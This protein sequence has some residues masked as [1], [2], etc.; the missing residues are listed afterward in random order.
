MGKKK[1]RTLLFLLSLCWGGSSFAAPRKAPQLSFLVRTR[2]ER[3]SDAHPLSAAAVT[4][5]TEFGFSEEHILGVPGLAARIEVTDV[6]ALISRY[7][8]GSLSGPTHPQRPTVADPTLTRVTESYLSL[9]RGGTTLLLGRKKLS[10]DDE[11]FVGPVGWRQMPQSFGLLGVEGHPSAETDYFFAYLFQRKGIKDELNANYRTGSLL[12]HFD[13]KLAPLKV[14]AFAYLLENTHD[15]YG[16]ATRYQRKSSQALAEAAWQLPPTLQTGGG[17]PQ[18]RAF[19][20]RLSWDKEWGKLRAGLSLSFLGRARG[21]AVTGFSTP[22]A[23][24]HKFE[25]FA[26][27]LLSKSANGDPLG[28][29]DRELRLG[30]GRGNVI[31]HDFSSDALHKDYGRELDLS[32]QTTFRPVALLFKGAFYQAGRDFGKSTTKL[33]VVVEYHHIP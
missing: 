18:K 12:F 29:Q 7:N 21:G 4:T 26:D 20:Y 15:T 32:Y 11:R 23:T 25:G 8:A 6:S 31:L 28:V 33:W 3:V 2:F 16:L 27:V 1:L 13:R 30:F 22:L 19:F 24:L 10:L 17:S 14:T 5:K 9:K